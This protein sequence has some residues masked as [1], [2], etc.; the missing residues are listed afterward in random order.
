MNMKFI[1][2]RKKLDK[3]Q[4]TNQISKGVIVIRWF[5]PTVI[6]RSTFID[7]SSA[8]YS[9]FVS[10][11]DIFRHLKR[12]VFGM[13]IRAV[14][15]SNLKK[16]RNRNQHFQDTGIEI[17]IEILAG[18]ESKSEVPMPKSAGICGIGIGT[19]ATTL[20]WMKVFLTKMVPERSNILYILFSLPI[21][22]IFFL[23]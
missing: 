2:F 16:N 8:L 14:A 1:N 5:L 18:S 6:N 11:L 4:S 23:K 3:E 9:L 13:W 21:F 15:E 22:V 10:V 17:G 12:L 20:M 7:L 19:F